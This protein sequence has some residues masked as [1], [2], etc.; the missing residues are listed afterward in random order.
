[1]SIAAIGTYLPPW[2]S[3]AARVPGRD[4]DALTMAVQA[5]RAALGAARAGVDHVVFVTHDLPLLDGGNGAALVAGLGLPASTAVVEQIGG[6]PAALDALLA[7]VAGTLVIGA[8][9]GNASG[10]AAALVGHG[11][12]L[13]L[14]AVARV[15]RS[16]PV[17]A[18]GS[19]GEVHEYD[20]PRLVRERGMRAA[21]AD[22]GIA[23]KA[24]AAVGLPAKDAAALCEGDAPRASTIGASSPVF[25]LAAL[26]DARA[27]GLLLA[28]EQA[29]MTAVDVT[30]GPV[31]V[32]RVERAAQQM[33]KQR[34]TPGP[35]IRIS[36]PAYERAFEAKVRLE[37][38]RCPHCGTLALPPRHRCLGC[39]AEGDSGLA[40]LPREATVY[41][42]TTIHTPVPGVA[43]P[44]TIVIVDLGDT[45]VRL[46]AQVTGAPPGNVRI[47]DRGEMVLRRVAERSGIPDYGYA[48]SPAVPQ[49]A[50]R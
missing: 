31:T 18:R 39:G 20:D 47:G 5:G 10:A 19:D 48:F 45:G 7:A 32:T 41:T 16:L 27:N 22:A 43:T 4:E 13:S 30:S 6:G 33:P 26:A 3:A 37:A 40:E 28:F 15:L 12:G 50:T 38:G 23:R 35:E 2:G 11:D 17:R 49:E 42:T 46:L 44:Y 34:V 24:V 8:D 9:T 1:M 14:T 21:L 29:T 25:A 36:L